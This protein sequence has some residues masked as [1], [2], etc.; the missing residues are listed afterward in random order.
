VKRFVRCVLIVAVCM[1]LGV[2]VVVCL[3][4][5][6]LATVFG[7]DPEEGEDGDGL[8]KQIRRKIDPTWEKWRDDHDELY[9]DG[10]E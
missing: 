9:G 6:A 4:L 3:P 5:I 2:V 7:P 8:M 10:D 1:A